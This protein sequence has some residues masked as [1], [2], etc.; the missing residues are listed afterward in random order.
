MCERERERERERE[1]VRACV[2]VCVCAKQEKLSHPSSLR[3]RKTLF[4][5][6]TSC[7]PIRNGLNGVGP[8]GNRRNGEY[9][10]E[11]LSC[12]RLRLIKSTLT[13]GD[14][15]EKRGRG[16]TSQTTCST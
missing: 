8:N 9:W 2:C 15:T 11:S 13:L 10:S 14:G 4:I 1:C 12:V 6:N 16:E 5:L 3:S 7:R